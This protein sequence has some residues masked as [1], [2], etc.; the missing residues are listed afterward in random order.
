MWRRGAAIPSYGPW[1]NVF[2][3]FRCLLECWSWCILDGQSG[4]DAEARSSVAGAMNRN[5]AFGVAPRGTFSFLLCWLNRCH[6]GARD[7][8]LSTAARVG[9]GRLCEEQRLGLALGWASTG[10]DRH[11]PHAALRR[12]RQ[13][14][15]SGRRNDTLTEQPHTGRGK[16]HPPQEPTTRV[17]RAHSI[18]PLFCGRRP[19]SPIPSS[20][21][22]RRVR[23][24]QRGSLTRPAKSRVCP[25]THTLAECTRPTR[26]ADH[27]QRR[28]PTDETNQPE[29][30]AQPP[31]SGA[32]TTN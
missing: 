9:R 17:H 3:A 15:R 1:R 20:R 28:A 29:A 27:Q 5:G 26:R 12:R 23:V 16:S 2:I 7:V 11:A 31:T 10:S 14:T 25:V 6:R 19:S 30:T 8:R 4:Q 32:D 13:T 18:I 22:G 24:G 21:V